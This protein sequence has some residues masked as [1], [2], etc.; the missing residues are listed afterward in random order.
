[1]ISKTAKSFDHFTWQA[2]QAAFQLQAKSQQIEQ[3][4]ARKQKKVAINTNQVFADIVK[5]KEAKEQAKR[6]QA[7]WDARN[8]EGEAAETAR[9]LFEGNINR[10]MHEWHVN[11]PIEDSMQ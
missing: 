7:A 6:Q 9:I 3:L 5:I 10:F 11:A 4:K 8:P 2:T 1:M